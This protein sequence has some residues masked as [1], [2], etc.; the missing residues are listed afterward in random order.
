MAVAGTSDPVGIVMAMQAPSA[1]VTGI[2]AAET[3]MTGAAGAAMDLKAALMART[4][5]LAR[6][7]NPYRNRLVDRGQIG[8]VGAAMDVKAAL[9]VRTIILARFQN[10]YRNRLV[11]RDRIG[12]VMAMAAVENV[13]ACTNRP[14][15]CHRAQRCRRHHP[16]HVD[17]MQNLRHGLVPTRHAS[18]TS[19]TGSRIKIQD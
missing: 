14:T 13:H 18:V 17:V 19:Q 3:A 9:M 16:P 1:M 5:I 7:R 10:P 15:A 2:I 12:A 6:F 4:T 8:A 11:G